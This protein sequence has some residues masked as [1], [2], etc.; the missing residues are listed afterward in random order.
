M[1]TARRWVRIHNEQGKKHSAAQSKLARRNCRWPQLLARLEPR[2]IRHPVGRGWVA[3][4]LLVDWS[5]ELKNQAPSQELTKLVRTSLSLPAVSGRRYRGGRDQGAPYRCQ[6]ER[7]FHLGKHR[8]ETSSRREMV[9]PSPFVS[10]VSPPTSRGV[11]PTTG[12]ERDQSPKNPSRLARVLLLRWLP[13]GC[14]PWRAIPPFSQ[15]CASRPLI[16]R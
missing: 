13:D 9:H 8:V 14:E 16:A 1:L 15:N 4:D 5:S 3:V 12:D 7:S 11:S 2:E 6:A 10:P